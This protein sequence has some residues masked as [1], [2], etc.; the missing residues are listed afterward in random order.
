MSNPSYPFEAEPDEIAADPGPFVESVINSLQSD[1]LLVPKGD[2]FIE[3]DRFRAAYEVL[4]R[5][6]DDFSRT[7]RDRVWMAVREDAL[8]LV[9]L[10]VILGF[11]PSEWAKATQ[12]ATGTTISGEQAGGLDRDIRAGKEHLRLSRLQSAD[13]KLRVEAMISTACDLIGQGTGDVAADVIHRLD[14][15]DTREGMAGLQKLA[16]DGVA[17]DVL[18]YE[19]LLG[20]PFATLRDSVSRQVGDVMELAVLDRLIAARVPFY[21][22]KNR[23]RIEGFPVAPD[24]FIPNKTDPAAVVEAKTVVSAK[25]EE[26]RTTRSSRASTDVDLAS[27]PNGCGRCSSRRTARS[28]R[29]VR[30]TT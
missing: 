17:Y 7:E 4:R 11:S 8:S 28:S 27:A 22:T 10:R 21:K 18:L 2:R 20:R 9:V 12:E 1:F 29:Q 24:F 19:R 16:A 6:T 26:S 5:S 23:E 13:K 14:K 3:P 15:V 25:R 30:S